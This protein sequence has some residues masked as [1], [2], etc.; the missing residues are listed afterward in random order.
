[1]SSQGLETSTLSML[2]NGI[3]FS[4]RFGLRSLARLLEVQ[5][6]HKRVERGMG[7]DGAYHLERMAVRPGAQGGG[8]GS[9]CL[10]A[11]LAEAAKKG[12]AVVL[13]TQEARNVRF[14]E[15]LG[16]E[17]VARDERYFKTAGSSG[18]TNWV[19]LKRPPV[20]A[21]GAQDRGE[22]VSQNR[23]KAARSDTAR[24]GYVALLGVVVLVCAMAGLRHLAET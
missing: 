1:M 8:I 3:L 20:R 10:G 16:F 13:S 12:C 18:E 22:H 5:E 2:R 17:E 4:Y 9:R 19:M 24:G 21:G 7:G 14:Y 6:Y 15:R 23:V 11:A